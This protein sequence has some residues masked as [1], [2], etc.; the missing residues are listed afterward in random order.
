MRRNMAGW[1]RERNERYRARKNKTRS[2]THGP[3]KFAPQDT[4]QVVRATGDEVRLL[5]AWENTSGVGEVIDSWRDGKSV[6]RVQAPPDKE[7]KLIDG[8]VVTNGPCTHV[9]HVQGNE[10]RG[11]RLDKASTRREPQELS[12][13]DLVQHGM[14]TVHE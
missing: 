5:R 8:R 9:S 1:D 14:V 12:F 3:W 6:I 13:N 10:A 7:R 11:E 4:A 2:C